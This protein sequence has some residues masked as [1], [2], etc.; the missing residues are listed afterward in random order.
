MACIGPEQ[1]EIH[2]NRPGCLPIGFIGRPMKGFVFVDSNG[3]D[4]EEDL[5]FWINLCLTYNPKAN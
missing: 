4:L 1:E 5:L 3:F 2:K